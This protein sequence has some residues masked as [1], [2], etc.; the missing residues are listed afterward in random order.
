MQSPVA[1]LVVLRTGEQEVASRSPPWPIF[2]P[3][4]DYIHLDRIHSY[5]TAV[6][7]FDNGYMGK[8]PVAWKEY[9]AEHWLKELLRKAW[10]GVLATAI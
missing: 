8:Q 1:Q 9:C 5:L 10:I 3:T 2:F 4:I 7:C 6:C